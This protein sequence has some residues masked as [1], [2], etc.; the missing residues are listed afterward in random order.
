MFILS[1]LLGNTY[2]AKIL[3]ILIE[4]YKDEFT[5]PD[6]IE[7]AGTSRGS[8]YSYI[9]SLIS[10]NI[11]NET[12]KIGS[13]QLYKLNLENQSIKALILLEHNL[14]QEKLEKVMIKE[15]AEFISYPIE[16]NE[17]SAIASVFNKTDGEYVGAVT[18]QPKV[19][20]QSMRTG[21]EVKWKK[22][23]STIRI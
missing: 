8:T 9:K 3:E 21:G 18:F 19:I 5:I 15:K 17:S 2:Y 7:I 16:K 22:K 6:I 23:K 10:E 12:R 20:S 11:V 14:V 13:T 1:K 4:N